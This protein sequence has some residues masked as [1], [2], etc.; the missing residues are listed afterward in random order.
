MATFAMDASM[1]EMTFFNSQFTPLYSK[2]WAPLSQGS[3]AGTCIFLIILSITFRSLYAL[4]AM[5]EARWAEQA[6]N[7]RYIV[8]ADK[9]PISEQAK[10]DPD[11]KT[12]VLTANGVEEGVRLVQQPVN[13]LPPWRF[14]VDLPRAALVTVIV[15]IGYLL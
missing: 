10:R 13:R 4:K 3:Y 14:S 9:Q 12:A 11:L 15:G 6:Y 2:D 1:M 8:V 5:L 7:R